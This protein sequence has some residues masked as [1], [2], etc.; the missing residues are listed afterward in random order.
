M[1]EYW[2]HRTQ[3]ALSRAEQ[4]ERERDEQKQGWR[5]CIHDLERT[6]RERDEAIGALKEISQERVN[7]TCFKDACHW[8]A[9]ER[10]TREAL[11]E[12]QSLR[13]GSE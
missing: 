5:N 8:P 13:G 4:A 3:E 12:F 11:G 9:V 2:I 1:S 7:G 10:I 6:V